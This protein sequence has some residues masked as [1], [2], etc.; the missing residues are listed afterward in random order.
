MIRFWVLLD[1]EGD[2]TLV[3]WIK[4]LLAIFLLFGNDR[5]NPISNTEVWCNVEKTYHLLAWSTLVL[6]VAD[7]HNFTYQVHNHSAVTETDIFMSWFENMFTFV[8]CKIM[9]W[10]V[11]SISQWISQYPTHLSGMW[12]VGTSLLCL[13]KVSYFSSSH[14]CWNTNSSSN[15]G[16]KNVMDIIQVL[17]Y[18]FLYTDEKSSN[19]PYHQNVDIKKT[20]KLLYHQNINLGLTT[21][22]WYV[23]SDLTWIRMRI[24][25]V[26][27]NSL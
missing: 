5:I 17:I 20:S 4:W 15:Q 1:I 7:N 12:S 22:L 13:W 9:L 16:K 11:F 25:C 19:L 10:F 26:F 18:C 6:N 24:S 2:T 21:T 14:Y 27:S 3:C 8:E 23:V